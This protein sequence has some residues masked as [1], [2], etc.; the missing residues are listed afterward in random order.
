MTHPYDCPQCGE[1]TPELHEGYCA[2]CCHDNQQRLD[3]H[4]AHFDAWERMSP[5]QRDARIRDAVRLEG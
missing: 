4:N 2:E 5:A 3:A 1:G